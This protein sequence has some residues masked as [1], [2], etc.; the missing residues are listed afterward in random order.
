M[1]LT[2]YFFIIAKMFGS[3]GVFAEQVTKKPAEFNS[4]GWE[5]VQESKQ[6]PLKKI[7]WKSYKEDKN[8]FE[9][10]NSKDK[11]KKNLY[12]TQMKSPNWS[13]RILQFLF[14]K[15]T[16]QMLANTWVCTV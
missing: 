2:F 16:C 12:R 11:P 6:K 10:T 3:L 7:I 1:K 5:K 4:T 14:E 15:L 13:N 9:H 8:Y